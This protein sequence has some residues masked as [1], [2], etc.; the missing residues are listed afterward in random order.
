MTGTGEPGPSF[1]GRTYPYLPPRR[2]PEAVVPLLHAERAEVDPT[3]FEVLRHALWN[4]N[5]E[6]GNA[7]IRTSGSPVVVYA[8]DFNPVI[9]D[10]AGD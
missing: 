9:L 8:H 7:I 1:D 6:H 2:P 10:E 3:T 4:L 5:M